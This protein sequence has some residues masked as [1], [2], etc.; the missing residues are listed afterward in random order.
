M[1]HIFLFR[2]KFQTICAPLLLY[3]VQ[4]LIFPF[5]DFSTV[6]QKTIII[7]KPPGNFQILASKTGNN[8]N[9][10]VVLRWQ[11]CVCH[12]SCWHVEFT[13]CNFFPY[14]KIVERRVRKLNP[15]VNTRAMLKLNPFAAVMKRKAVLTAR[16]RLFERELAVAEKRKVSLCSYSISLNKFPIKVLR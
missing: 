8:V 2:I 6:A 1:N 7:N 13:L 9:F 14:S 4:K 10:S 3:Y 15:L 11:P 5:S 16:K 12:S